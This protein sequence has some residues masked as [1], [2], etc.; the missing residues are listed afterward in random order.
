MQLREY[1]D[2]TEDYINIQVGNVKLKTKVCFLV[3]ACFLKLISCILFL[4]LDNHRNQLIQV[5]TNFS[6]WIVSGP[7]HSQASTRNTHMDCLCVLTCCSCLVF[8]LFSAVRALSEFRDCLF[9]HIFL[10]GWNIWRK[11]PIHM[12]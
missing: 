11:H 7:I 5:L 3:Y 6:L 8:S 2:D 9:I 12:E 10:G 4:Q 1:I